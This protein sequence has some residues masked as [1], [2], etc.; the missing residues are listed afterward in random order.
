MRATT[1]TRLAVVVAGA[2]AT[3]L[4]GAA[5]LPIA[6]AAEQ[7]KESRTPHVVNEGIPSTLDPA[8]DLGAHTLSSDPSDSESIFA[9]S[10]VKGGGHEFGITLST[11]T[12][13][14]VGQNVISV[15]VTDVTTGWY[16][17]YQVP[18][19]TKDLYWGKTGLDIKT[20]DITWKGT[21]Q[22]MTVK[23]STPWG[24]VDVNLKAAGPALK[25]AGTGS[26]PLYGKTNYEYALPSM[27]T[28]G[29]LSVQ[30]KDYQVSGQTWV[31]RQ[32]GPYD[33]TDT[34]SRWTWMPI[35]LP[36]GDKL[37][38]WDSVSDKKGEN[39]W[40]TVMHRDGSYELAT[41]EPVAK[42]AHRIWTSPATGNAYPTR[43]SIDIPALRTHL[44]VRVTGTDAQEFTG[45]AGARYDGTAAYS[46]TFEGKKVDGVTYAEM[47]GHWPAS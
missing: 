15:S 21:A 22:N 17:G 39:A 26:F 5:V 23:A 25:A 12:L 29:T 3:A 16:K 46:G 6:Q 1:R 32:W 42:G 2:T 33:I 35:R 27:R 30:A 18:V 7:D 34:S 45:G 31:D 38:V 14:N 24:S 43:W 44:A 20:P 10:W 19:D 37:L 36:G 41:V 11:A 28:T 9:T 40:A 4:L 47:V 8:T 13:P